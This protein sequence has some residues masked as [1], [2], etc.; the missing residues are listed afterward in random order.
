[1]KFTKLRV[2]LEIDGE[3]RPVDLSLDLNNNSDEEI[4]RWCNM[5]EDELA[6]YIGAGVIH[7]FR[8]WEK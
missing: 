7:T 2:I 3:Q 6:S 5:E 8:N 4:N 1:M